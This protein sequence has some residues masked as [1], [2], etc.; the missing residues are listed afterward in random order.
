MV[1]NSDKGGS[2]LR[3][4][5]YLAAP[6]VEGRNCLPRRVV[7]KQLCPGRVYGKRLALSRD[8]IDGL[9]RELEDFTILLCRSAQRLFSG[10][11]PGHVLAND[12]DTD[13]PAILIHRAE[14]QLK[15]AAVREAIPG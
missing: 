3:I 10:F 5:P 13:C 1:H 7:P 2:L 14:G 12:G 15:V 11:L 6:I 8:A 4:E 9:R